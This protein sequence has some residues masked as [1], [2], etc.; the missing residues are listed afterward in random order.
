MALPTLTLDDLTWQQ[1]V[2][3]ARRR[4]VAASGSQWTLHAAVDPGVT[5]IE[6]VAWLLE[7][8]LYFADQVTPDLER[9]LLRLID[10]RPRPAQAAATVLQ[11]AS[12]RKTVRVAAGTEMQPL[13]QT[14]STLIF[15]TEESLTVAPLAD[16]IG[17]YA[18]GQDRTDE[19]AQSY[20]DLTT[21]GVPSDVTIAL[22]L[23]SPLPTAKEPALGLF[24]ELTNDA[25]GAEWTPEAATIASATK[26]E[27]WRRDG[28]GK[29][30]RF[31]SSGFH[32][33]TNGLRR[34]GIVRLPLDGWV[35]DQGTTSRYTVELR[36]ADT[37]K[38]PFP[39][40]LVGLWLNAALARHRRHVAPPRS[41]AAWLLLSDAPSLRLADG[42]VMKE[43]V[44]LSL[45]ERD[46]AWHRWSR[47][48]DVTASGPADRV[49]VVDRD[50]GVISFGDGLTGRLPTLAD[51]H[52]PPAANNV[53]ISYDVGGGIAGN[54]G[55]GQK[56]QAVG[57]HL[58]Q[59]LNLVD[60]VGGASDESTDDTRQRA[61]DDE[62]QV[63]RA[64]IAG[65]YET[66]AL[67][68]P[69]VGIARAHAA[70]GLH[71]S[72]SCTLAPGAV[73]VIVVPW[74]PRP[75]GG[76]DDPA[77]DEVG[78]TFA[79]MPDPGAIGAVCKRLDEA[80]LVATSVFVRGP[81]YRH[82]ALAVRA[83]GDPRDPLAWQTAIALRLRVFLDPLRGGDDSSGWPF[84]EPL[85]PSALL[86][87]AQAAIGKEGDITAV[88][89]TLDGVAPTN[90]CDDVVIGAHNLVVLEATEL[91]LS[92][93]VPTRSGLR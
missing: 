60:C 39:P 89:I 26:V 16:R 31:P 2:D 91:Q 51:N 63:T 9:A 43:T 48:D 70:V 73:T 55:S 45:Q 24:F 88:S 20:V 50:R 38:F 79:P 29:S 40:R 57:H 80:R 71:P 90:D 76:P 34:S 66:L 11:F 25:I 44:H 53:H 58:F 68:T 49:F 83:E 67:T 22:P 61:A 28:S 86:R 46:A 64:V 18:R 87:E 82:A 33:G 5:L 81:V 4:I 21:A 3:A 69:G 78:W 77:W 10:E 13:L 8:R 56:W 93:V 72:Y 32:D 1:M 65:D 54:V 85:R 92:R 35:A 23:V 74:A 37:A 41:H 62:R 52:A 15:S 12:G 27:F 75:S 14:R 7:Q 59:A 42:P 17:L 36:C 19:F 6:L 47:V 84:G 30:A